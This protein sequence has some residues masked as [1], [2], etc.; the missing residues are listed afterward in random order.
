MFRMN[1]IKKFFGEEASAIIS[2]LALLLGNV[3]SYAFILFYVRDEY[4]YSIIF[5]AISVVWFS[6][7]SH[8]IHDD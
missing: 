3:C 2:G 8:L 7:A 1:K 5:F 4:L 6:L